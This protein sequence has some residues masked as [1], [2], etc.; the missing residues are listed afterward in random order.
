MN[1]LK[2]LPQILSIN[3]F[4]YGLNRMKFGIRMG[5]TKKGLGNRTLTT[6]KV[7]LSK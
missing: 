6:C 4:I 3:C 7:Q 2:S 1:S 5:K